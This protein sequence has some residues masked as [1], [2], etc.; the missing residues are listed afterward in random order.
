M[1]AVPRPEA[2]TLDLSELPSVVFGRRQAVWW[3]TLGFMVVEGVTLCATLA[4]WFYIRQNFQE[5]PPPG[6]PL[7]DLTAG[8][9]GLLSLFLGFVPY[10][11]L[12][13]AA[14]R[15]DAVAVRRWL[16]VG[17]AASLLATAIRFAELSALNA[18]FD[19]NAYSSAVWA[20]LVTH[21]TLLIADV[22]ETGTAAMIFT[23]RREEPKHFP[24]ASDNS[25]YWYFLALSWVPGYVVVY[26]LPRVI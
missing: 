8:T 2:E 24:D 7:P 17:T 20:V 14:R 26:W 11:F 25:F 16:W 9:V 22:F 13:R 23:L 18:P 10:T 21:L 6:T 1:T 5:W 19:L 12:D 3:G 4:T 15:L